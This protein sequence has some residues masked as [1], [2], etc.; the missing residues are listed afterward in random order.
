MKNRVIANYGTVQNVKS[1]NS[2]KKGIERYGTNKLRS[3]ELAIIV[4][5]S[6]M[7]CMAAMATRNFT[8]GFYFEFIKKRNLNRT[9]G[10]IAISMTLITTAVSP[11]LFRFFPKAIKQS[12]VITRCAVL[13]FLNALFLALMGVLDLVLERYPDGQLAFAIISVLRSLQGLT[14]GLLVLI[15]Q[16]EMVDLYLR[17][18]KIL[19]II[20]SCSMHVA[21]IISSILAAQLY[22]WGGW[23]FVGLGLATF[24][25]LPLF[26]IPAIK[27]VQR[28]A[29]SIDNNRFLENSGSLDDSV[30]SQKGSD[31][32]TCI[33]EMA[34]YMP[35]I[36]L[37][38]N[39]V[40]YNILI[41]NLTERIVTF[42]GNDLDTAVLLMNSLNVFA[43]ISALVL[44]YITD[45]KL[46]VFSAMIFGN[47]AF[48]TG[49]IFTFGSTT[50]F[51]FLKFP[52]G[53]EVGSVLIGIGDAAIA[54]LS[55]MS[56]FVLYERWGLTT[57]GL[58]ARSTAV[59]NV[60]VNLSVAL[61][62]VLSGF[63][64]SRESEVPVLGGGA[65]VFILVGIGL[66]LCRVVK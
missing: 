14:T 54:N 27:V 59:N 29:Q 45:K 11:Y 42:S 5:F 19:I 55:I 39:N 4:V 26:L 38:L 61:G 41:F 51:S 22:S 49:Y 34:F 23:L 12:P 43:L 64:L 28:R 66:I 44:A 30:D 62:I 56:K 31:G 57:E 36:A 9:I 46:N 63:T 15:L 60:A 10:T 37:F 47:V 2:E 33:R 3:W 40:L 8:S 17:E 20:I 35:D 21:N 58:G 6:C 18:Y 7:G 53:F 16:G 52:Y 13:F 48:Q 32:I 25:C 65:G 24:T 50:K 1:E